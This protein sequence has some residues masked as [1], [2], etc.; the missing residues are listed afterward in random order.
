M[1]NVFG[2]RTAVDTVIYATSVLQWKFFPFSNGA[3]FW[4][5]SVDRCYMMATFYFLCSKK[6]LVRKACEDT[7]VPVVGHPRIPWPFECSRFH[8]SWIDCRRDFGAGTV[9]R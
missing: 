9:R 2:E 5:A 1:R 7:P 6:P 3:F 4:S 8:T